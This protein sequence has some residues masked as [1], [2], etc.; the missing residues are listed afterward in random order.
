[1]TEGKT[2]QKAVDTLGIRPLALMLLLPDC[3]LPL[4]THQAL[5]LS[6][7]YSHLQTLTWTILRAVTVVGVV[8]Q[9]TSY[10]ITPTT[11]WQSNY[12]ETTLGP[13]WR[14]LPASGR[15]Y[16]HAEY[17]DH[18]RQ[19]GVFHSHRCSTDTLLDISKSMALKLAFFFLMINTPYA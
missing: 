16:I 7:S 19:T 4:H 17:A 11:V 6:L 12:F 5:S 9:D 14:P 2:L 3:S 8:E 18:L 1:M 13:K 10:V 15:D